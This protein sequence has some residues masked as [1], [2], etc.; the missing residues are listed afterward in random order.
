MTKKISIKATKTLIFI[1]IFILGFGGV[2][3][4]AY[5]SISFSNI[6]IE[7]G[8][9]QATVE[10]ILQ[11]KKGYI[12]FGT[13]N[14][15]NRYNGYDFKV[16][17]HE[18]GNPSSI[19]NNYIVDL[20]EDFEGNIWVGTANGISKISSDEET[21]TNY[22][23]GEENG[24]LSHYNIWE[25]L[26][27]RNGK[28]LVSTANGLNFY[29]EKTDSFKRIFNDD[30]LSSQMIYSIDEDS[31]GN[32][33]L[34]TD[35][36]LNMI[37]KETGEI[38][39]Y[40]HD[41]TKNSIAE[42][43]IYKVYCDDNGFIWLG[44]FTKGASRINRK[45]GEI[46]NYYKDSWG[47]DKYPGEHI[48]DF[49][50]DSN[51]DLWICSSNGLVKYDYNKFILYNNKVYD[52]RSL[53]NDTVFTIIEDRTGM[54][55]AGTYAGVSVF[56]SSNSIVHY[57]ND[58]FDS[59]TI[60]ENMI[61]SIYEDSD[62]YL[63]VGTHTKGVDILDGDRKKIKT[64]S[65]EDNEIISGNRVN[66]IKGYKNYIFLA[67]NNGLNIIDRD[68]KSIKIIKK[69]EGLETINIR[70]LWVDD[71][72]YLWIGTID[73]IFVMNIDTNTIENV[74]YILENAETDD[75]YSGYIFQDSEGIYWIGNFVNGGL[76]KIDPYT[77]EVT[78]YKYDSN[79]KNSLIDNVVRTIVEDGKG[80]IWI[81]TSEGLSVLDKKT[82]SFTNYTTKDGLPND[83]IYGILIDDE[84]NLWLSTNNGLSR[85]DILNQKFMNF[86][87]TDGLQSNEFNGGAYFKS[88]SGEFFFGGING[89]NSFYPA[90]IKS[91]NYS[92]N[93]VF[94]EFRVNGIKVRD[95][96]GK[97]F[98]HDQNNIGIQVFLPEY[99]NSKNIRYYYSLNDDDWMPM[100]KTTVLFSELSPGKYNFK[101][102]AMNSNGIVSE[103]NELSFKIKMP[104]LISYPALA[105]YLIVIIIMI[106][107]H[108]NKLNRLDTLVDRRTKELR[109]EMEINKT[110]FD[111]IIKL[112]RDKNSYFINLSHELRTPLN[113]LH[114]IEQ[115]IST[116]NKSG[117]IE[118]SKLDYYMS[119]MRKNNNRLLSLINNLIDIS[120]MENGK[121]K[122]EKEEV[123]IVYLVEEAA[124]SMKEYI[125]EKGISL[126]IDPEVEEKI[127]RC[128][129][130]DI[131]RCILNLISNAT[132]FTPEGGE[133]TVLIEDLNEK[134]R[135]VVKDTGIGI[136]DEFKDLIF[137]RF[138]QVVDS[139]A[140]VKGGSGLGLTITKQIVTLHKGTIYVESKVGEGSSFIIE[141]PV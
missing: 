63:W 45:T 80:N 41:D 28:I 36:G 98:S 113:V 135:I 17:N 96:N 138:D 16:Y 38:T 11:D 20:K 6:T 48:R 35:N 77:K 12:W 106:K 33:W 18:K 130:E 79:N 58:P 42:N 13:N 40:Y 117:N 21:I 26:I 1:F 120:K 19:I 74:T 64:L 105:F 32:I 99:K 78:N 31:E 46:T 125:E 4:D 127:I 7:D 110:L 49:Y 70:N 104:F 61:Q 131:E 75:Y 5:D 68:N 112:E 60:S 59:T 66:A 89:M 101:I 137:N 55:W 82:N 72:G 116:L 44:T 23:Q 90:D 97:V 56:D 91:N 62:G 73:G 95:I 37:S 93:V 124:L 103:S 86:N 132:K 10:T 108:K 136:P 118:R 22:S 30:S 85:F 76:T 111:K 9:S 15:L 65:F 119:I 123:D 114:T 81:G 67:T 122:I 121:Y 115:L 92:E 50:K 94:D 139:D 102:K 87:I 52:N 8:L 34:A 134:V 140:E 47:L 128:D 107:L 27:L 126:I 69:E 71:K 133:I 83:T 24:G 29:D 88:K 141:L 84:D 3:C 54:L 2:K 57:K 25:I 53:V 43:R 51:G 14:G 100:D 109:D 129:G 39:R